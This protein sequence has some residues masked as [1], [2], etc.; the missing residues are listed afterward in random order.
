M[1]DFVSRFLW[2]GKNG[3]LISKEITHTKNTIVSEVFFLTSDS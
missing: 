2:A 1:S 3:R